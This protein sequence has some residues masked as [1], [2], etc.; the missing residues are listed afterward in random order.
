MS[1]E[2]KTYPIQLTK[3]EMAHVKSAMDAWF[4]GMA[5]TSRT[6]NIKASETLKTIADA[7]IKICKALELDT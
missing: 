2:T 1:E 7:H 3:A 6:Y 4:H 5:A